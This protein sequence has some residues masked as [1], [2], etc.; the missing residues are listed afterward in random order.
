MLSSTFKYWDG[1]WFLEKSSVWRHI[2][3]MKLYNLELY[4]ARSVDKQVT[5]REN[6]TVNKATFIIRRHQIWND[7]FKN[8]IV[9]LM[10]NLQ[11]YIRSW[12]CYPS[13]FKFFKKFFLL[14]AFN[15]FWVTPYSNNGHSK[16]SSKKFIFSWVETG[17]SHS[18]I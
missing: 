17:D 11:I 13:S 7:K 15:F 8:I 6:D 4:M 16:I 18:N 12:F 1:T 2:I 5:K 10:K 9:N 14:F 3:V